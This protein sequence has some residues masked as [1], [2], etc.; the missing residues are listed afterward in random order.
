MKFRCLPRIIGT[1]AAIGVIL[2]GLN[3]FR[4]TLNFRRSFEASRKGDAV[5]A[6]KY[7]LAGA[8]LS[9][10]FPEQLYLSA[11]R[12]LLFNKN[13]PLALKLAE[14]TEKTPYKNF[15]RIH[16]IKA[17]S[18]ALL[19]RDGEAAAEYLLESKNYPYLILPRIGMITCYGRLGRTELIPPIEK[20]LDELIKFRGLSVEDV[21]KIMIHPECDL[22]QHKLKELTQ[23]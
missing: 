7:A 5:N 19:G 1:I 8:A 22:N 10:S 17:M 12:A 15:S 23:K 14:M 3:N 21:R 4:A 9:L 13:Y 20:E 11:E 6:Q 18:L 16:T 2:S